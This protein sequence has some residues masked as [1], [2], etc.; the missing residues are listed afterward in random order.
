M[1]RTFGYLT[2]DQTQID[3]SEKAEQKGPLE[4]A[5]GRFLKSK[6]SGRNR[7]TFDISQ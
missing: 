5:I 2:P 3:E 6:S 1:I 4:L 7:V